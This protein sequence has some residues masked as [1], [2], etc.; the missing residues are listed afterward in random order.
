MIDGPVGRQIINFKRVKPT[1]FKIKISRG[2][3]SKLVYEKLSKENF[4]KRWFESKL[5][6]VYLKKKKKNNFSDYEDFKLMLGKKYKRRF[7][8]KNFPIFQKLLK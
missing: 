6:K 4:L 8:I 1:K 3:S 7:S 5:G 2:V